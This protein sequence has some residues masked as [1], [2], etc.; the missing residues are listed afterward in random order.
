MGERSS[1]T[2]Y[3]RNRPGLLKSAGERLAQAFL[4]ESDRWFLWIPVLFAA[5][6]GV[7]FALDNEP[8][9]LIAIAGVTAAAG[10]VL[11]TRRCPALWALS[12]AALCAALGFADIKL[13]ATTLATPMLARDSRAVTVKGWVER[14]EPRLPTGYRLTLR[15]IAIDGLREPVKLNRVRVTSRFEPAPGAGSAVR[16]RAVLR[17]VP[18]P[19]QPG[20]FDF[21]RKIWFAGIGAVGFSLAAPKPL[22]NAPDPG[23]L[24]K[25]RGAI[26]S[27]RQKVDSRIR[28]VIAGET[29][30]IASA[31][32]TG[33][34]GRIPEE[35]LRALRHSGLAHVLAISGLHMALM[36]GTLYW[37]ARAGMALVPSL[38]LR[39]P[40]KKIAAIVALSG[41]GF[42]LALS[43]AGIA[44]QRAFLMMAIL[45][46]AILLDRPALTLRN[47]ALAAIVVLAMFPESVFDVSFQMS[48]AAAAALVAVYE[49]WSQRARP[50]VSQSAKSRF[51]RRVL[52][53]FSGIALTTVVAGIA[54]APFAA[55]HFHKLAQYSL[56]ANLATMPLFTLSVMPMALATLLA[57]PLGL[58]YWPLQAMAA[59]IEAIV[60][61]AA[62][63]SA[64]PGSVVRVAAMPDFSLAALTL[65]GLWIIL[66][67]GRW[68]FAGLLFAAAGLAAAGQ[69]PKPD[70]LITS[71]GALVA[72][73]ADADRLAAIA[74]R[75]GDY[76]LERWLAAD[77][78]DRTA[79]LARTSDAFTCDAAAC[80]ATIRGK[81][82][83]WI[84]HP[85]A[86][87]EECERADIVVAQF[88]LGKRCKGARVSIDR[89]E[90]LKQGAQALYLDGQSIVKKSVAR[91][92]GNRPWTRTPGAPAII[93][94]RR[95]KGAAHAGENRP[96]RQ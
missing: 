10:L 89:L 93:A 48:F 46:L 37:L 40:I 86:L 62:A 38:A 8:S 34:R 90:L 59:G 23:V 44:T 24:L 6:I 26:H 13:R 50:P 96:A 25:T 7:Y 17:P 35:T 72:V 88:P 1:A 51:A 91:A 81:A 22:E 11:L 30:A 83:A 54:V 94:G 77:G 71:D 3:R 33:E 70:M 4:A 21:A 78:D 16:V 60:A 31:L 15:V 76:S 84:K 57:M 64:W 73:R 47:V 87:G 45:F 55:F 65:G 20:G 36:A 5:G 18:Q 27:L 92:R 79:R 28:A 82:V 2:A 43:G 19:V 42:Y 68:R 69:L 74:G 66:W 67:R 32:V 14:A 95:G 58:E 52:Y 39:A 12:L 41:G 85:S 75:K 80:V 63:V 53:Y 49:R 29:G 56:I 9:G 61:I